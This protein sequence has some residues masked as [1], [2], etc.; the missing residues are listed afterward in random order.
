MDKG[1]TTEFGLSSLA[2]LAQ[3]KKCQPAWTEGS[4]V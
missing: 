2:G 1:K 4:Q 3:W